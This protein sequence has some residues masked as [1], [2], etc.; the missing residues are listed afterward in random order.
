MNKTQIFKKDF[1]YEKPI[2]FDETMIFEGV[3]YYC[4]QN[5]LDIPVSRYE[6]LKAFS[7]DVTPDTNFHLDVYEQLSKE[8]FEIAQE[9]SE[10]STKV[11]RLI[12][13]I[14]IAIDT[15]K[16]CTSF[17]SFLNMMT[18]FFLRADENPHDFDFDLHEEKKAIFKANKKKFLSIPHLPEILVSLGLYS[19]NDIKDFLMLQTT[20]ELQQK[21]IAKAR[22]FILDNADLKE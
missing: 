16:N 8:I 13:K 15:T 6:I 10:F 17:D 2:I 9:P 11:G 21:Q 12:G 22:E 18:V 20:L 5:A 3:Q 1:G 19:L 14:Q 4:F 7:G